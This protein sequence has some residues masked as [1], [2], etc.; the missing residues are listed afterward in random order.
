MYDRVAGADSDVMFLG[1]ALDTGTQ[2]L[3]NRPA[4]LDSTRGE[5]LGS[6][7][8]TPARSAF[9]P[10]VGV[11]GLLRFSESLCA[12]SFSSRPPVRHFWLAAD[13]PHVILGQD[14]LIAPP[15]RCASLWPPHAEFVAANSDQEIR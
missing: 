4:S 2:S 6:T 15:S 3:A 7:S 1:L 9:N 8:V 5:S 13:C 11:L 12:R 14:A 10:G